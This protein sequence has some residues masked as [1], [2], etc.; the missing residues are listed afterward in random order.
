MKTKIALGLVSAAIVVGTLIGYHQ[1]S[2]NLVYILEL[3]RHGART[4]LV[5]GYMFSSPAEMLTPSGMRQRYLMGRYNQ[6]VYGKIFPDY[7]NM[8]YT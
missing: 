1:Q 4:P 2:E 6:E 8:I 7:F 3:A 5:D